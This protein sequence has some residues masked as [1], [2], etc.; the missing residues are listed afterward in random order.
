MSLSD[1]SESNYDVGGGEE[2]KFL[3]YEDDVKQAVA[4]LKE[5]SYQVPIQCPEGRIGCLVYH[6]KT[7]IDLSELDKI[8][9]EKLI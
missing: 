4:E 7:V 6:T 3:Y 5:K 8:F 1:K 9:G 2:E